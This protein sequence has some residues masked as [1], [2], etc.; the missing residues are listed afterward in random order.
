[1]IGRNKSDQST[2]FI[3]GNTLFEDV[4][5]LNE[6]DIEESDNNSPSLKSKL[7]VMKSSKESVYLMMNNE[8]DTAAVF[9][10]KSGS[11]ASCTLSTQQQFKLEGTVDHY[12][13]QIIGVEKMTNSL[14]IDD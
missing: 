11:L 6:S 1:M 2:V 7:L 5:A 12:D 8:I 13:A 9:K 14:Q 3:L 10:S 4:K